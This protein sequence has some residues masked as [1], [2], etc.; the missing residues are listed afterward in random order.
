MATKLEQATARAAKLEEK[1]AGVQAE[2]GAKA[3]AWDTERTLMGHG[4]TDPEAQDFAR[5]AYGRIPEA[6][7]PT[8]GDWLT[9]VKAD[10]TTAPAAL[11][12][13]LAGTAEAPA[14]RARS[15]PPGIT[16]PDAPGSNAT[17]EAVAARLLASPGSAD[18]RK[19]AEDRIAQLRAKRG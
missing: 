8:L 14:P 10:P 1:L 19:A 6:D 5:F 4:L 3:S 15:T 18:A 7:R 2:W 11:A 9:G 16:P 12:P 13:Y 17:A